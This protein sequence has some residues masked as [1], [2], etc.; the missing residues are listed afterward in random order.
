VAGNFSLHHRVQTG[1]E[2][3]TASYPVGTRGSFLGVKWPGRE[4]DHLRPY[5]ADVK[6]AW[7]YTSTPQYTFILP[8]PYK[9]SGRMKSEDKDQEFEIYMRKI[10]NY[11]T[12]WIIVHG[13]PIN[14]PT[15]L[16]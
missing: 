11:L 12:L 13:K 10:I 1:F 5:S 3:H 14:V 9:Y 7:S 15:N 4:A 2:T 16:A 6:N 8:L